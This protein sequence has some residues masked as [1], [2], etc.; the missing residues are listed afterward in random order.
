MTS[1]YIALG[2]NLDD[3]QSQLRKAV[4]ALQKLHK[5]DL[6]RVSSIYRSKAI[7]PGTQPD[8]LNAVALLTTRLAPL[9]LLDAL[10]QIERDQNRIRDVRWGPRTLD[11]D[12]LLYGNLTLELPRLTVPHPRM[13]ERN[14]VLYP[15]LEISDDHLVLPDGTALDAFVKLCPKAG[16]VKTGHRLLASTFTH[17][18]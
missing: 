13:Q 18:G 5:T 9:A 12:V 7:G 6:E 4:F 15:L 16:L 2:S 11:L 10:Q 17:S 14:F 3:P 1:V 8:Y